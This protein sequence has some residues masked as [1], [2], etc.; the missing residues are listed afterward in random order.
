MNCLI[1]LDRD[2]VI[3]VDSDAYI[4]TP[5]EWQAIPGSAEAIGRLV[6]AGYRVAVATNQ[7]GLARG[8]FDLDDLEAIHAKMED[9]IAAAGGELAGIFYCPHGPDDGCHCRKPK[10]GLLEA[11]GRELETD[12]TGVPFIGDALKDV[13]AALAVGCQA[14]LVRTGKGE[15]AAAQLPAELK[16]RVSIFD[17]LAAAVDHLL[18]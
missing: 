13:E 6:Q 4:K 14:I 10:P 15:T 9:T 16:Q 5:A 12:L 11:I 2:G 7:S 17:D 3:N 8:L 1:I 18:T